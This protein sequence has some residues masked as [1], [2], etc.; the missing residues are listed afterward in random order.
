MLRDAAAAGAGVLVVS[1]DLDE[2]RELAQRIVVLYGGRAVGE[3]PVAGATD[4]LL[5][6]WM[7]GAAA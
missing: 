2:L 7:A 1:F 3:T 6:K 4:A 5:S